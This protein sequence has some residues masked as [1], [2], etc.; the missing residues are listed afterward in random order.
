MHAVTSA[1]QMLMR[2]LSA[3][4][5]SAGAGG[6]NGCVA[7]LGHGCSHRGG[8]GSRSD[9]VF[10]RLLPP[11][12]TTP[13]TDA[14][15][16]AACKRGQQGLAETCVHEAVNDGVHAGRSVGQ[17]V[18]EGDG[19]PREGLGGRI[20]VK[21]PPGVGGVQGHPADEEERHDHHKHANDSLLGLQLG[22]RGVA[23]GAFSFG[24]GVVGR[25]GQSGELH[26][27]GGF[28]RHLDVASV[29]VIISRCSS[30]SHTVLLAWRVES[31]H[32]ESLQAV[33]YE[34]RSV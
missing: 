31:L 5:S 13:A 6:A 24:W 4:S 14:V 1:T 22:L 19:R 10:P 9:A 3:P 23:T 26:T 15:A 21:S 17:Q 33:R 16:A 30:P 2:P 32:L 25:G 18:D 28:L 7:D 34:S 8:H 20:L 12:L 11:A 27:G 29:V